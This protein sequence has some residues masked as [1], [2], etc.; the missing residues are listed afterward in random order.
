M[1]HLTVQGNQIIEVYNT[2]VTHITVT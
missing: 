1:I 2:Y